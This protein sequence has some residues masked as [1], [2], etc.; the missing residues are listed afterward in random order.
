[1][2][3]YA[4]EM[5]QGNLASHQERMRSGDF[6]SYKHSTYMR[7]EQEWVTSV[8]GGTIVTTDHWGLSVG[9]RYAAEGPRFNYYNFEGEKYGLIPV[10]SSREVFDAVKGVP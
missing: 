10:D 2:S 4:E 6:I 5:R 1:M 9:G 7:G 8:N 3:R